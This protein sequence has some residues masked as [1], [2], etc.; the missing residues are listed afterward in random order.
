M[1]EN[2]TTIWHE[3]KLVSVGGSDDR[4][5]ETMQTVRDIPYKSDAQRPNTYYSL[6]NSIMMVATPDDVRK[7]YHNTVKAGINTF[8]VGGGYGRSPNQTVYYIPDDMLTVLQE[9]KT[10]DVIKKKGSYYIIKGL[11]EYY[12]SRYSRK[13]VL[14]VK[15]MVTE[16]DDEF[17]IITSFRQAKVYD[18]SENVRKKI[19][20]QQDAYKEKIKELKTFTREQLKKKPIPKSNSF[21]ILGKYQATLER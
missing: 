3:F 2:K 11:K 6:P 12:P 5:N 20:V 18:L 9:Y 19:R 15:N 16:I 13:L 7:T 21:S 4:R 1:E 10:G 14:M 8:M 17:N